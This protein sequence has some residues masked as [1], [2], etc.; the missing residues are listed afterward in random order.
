MLF[1]PDAKIERQ[2]GQAYVEFIVVFPLMVLLFLFIAVQ[3]WYWWNQTSAAVAI[4][5]GTA[6]ASHHGGSIEAGYQETLRALAAPLG[7]TAQDYAGTY[8]IVDLPPLRATAGYLRN[9]RVIDLPYI[10]LELFT[11]EASSFQRREQFYGGPPDT[12]E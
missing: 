2:R 7:G 11:V 5:D 8:A 4:Y 10:G 1:K 9:E 6:A 12:F 3:A